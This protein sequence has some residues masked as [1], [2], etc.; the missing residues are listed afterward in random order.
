MILEIALGQYYRTGDIGCFGGIHGR[1]H[2]IGVSSLVCGYSVVL[3]YIPLIAWT[4]RAFFDSFRDF[5]VN[6]KADGADSYMYF[7]NDIIGMKTLGNI[8][9]PTRVVWPNFG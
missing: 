9:L 4:V 2:G 6:Y 7:L 1:L 3:Y 8:F 5:D